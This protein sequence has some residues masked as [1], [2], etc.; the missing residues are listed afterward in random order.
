MSASTKL[1]YVGAGLLG[2][3]TVFGRAKHP[4]RLSLLPSVG[5]KM[6]TSQT[7]DFY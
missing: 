2:W 3:V 1:L 7:V 6:S 4:G 5:R